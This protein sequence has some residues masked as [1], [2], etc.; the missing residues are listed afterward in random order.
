MN[1]SETY[2]PANI[3]FDVDGGQMP[4]NLGFEFPT[5]QSAIQFMAKYLIGINSKLRSSRYIDNFEKSEI[6]KDYQ[7][8]LE[9]KIPMLEREMIKAKSVFDEAKKDLADA[10][11]MVSATAKSL[12]NE[13]RRGVREM[14]KYVTKGVREDLNRFVETQQKVPFTVKNVY[15]MLQMIV[16]T[17]SD[18]MNKVLIEAFERICSFSDQ[19][20]TAGETWR[21]NSNYKINRK[22]IHPWICEYDT[23]WPEDHVKIKYGSARDDIDDIVKALCFLTGKQYQFDYDSSLQGF[24]YKKIISWGEWVIWNDFF[25]IKGFKKGTMHFEF[26]DQKVCDEFNLRVAKAKGWRLPSDTKHGPRSKSTD[27]VLF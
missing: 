12:A 13:V 27:V 6:R 23:R 5:H 16:G 2:R 25:R 17:Q 14:E 8:L 11:E 18:R 7:E 15:K 9:Q 10:T 1:T 19:N 24:F 3:E 26:L 21:T 4:M 20:S 22:F